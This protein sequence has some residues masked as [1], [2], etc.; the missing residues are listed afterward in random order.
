MS[1]GRRIG[2]VCH[3]RGEALLRPE[4][5]QQLRLGFFEGSFAASAYR[6]ITACGN[7][8]APYS[9]SNTRTATGNE[10]APACKN[11]LIHL[12]RP[13]DRMCGYLRFLVSHS[14]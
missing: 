7:A 9:P 6:H 11:F 3:E 13:T 10:N 12:F 1:N 5:C 14:A 2:D 4:D 8:S